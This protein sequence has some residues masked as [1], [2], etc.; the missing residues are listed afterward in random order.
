M[1]QQDF[2]L[3]P[4]DKELELH[5]APLSSARRSLEWQMEISRRAASKLNVDKATAYGVAIPSVAE[6]PHLSMEIANR[7]QC[8]RDNISQRGRSGIYD[9]AQPDRN[10]QRF[11][12]YSPNGFAALEF[13]R[14]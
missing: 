12:R 10:G 4:D 11:R 1:R 9:W 5:G 13:W 3:P 14:P 8:R 7:K 6:I 2:K